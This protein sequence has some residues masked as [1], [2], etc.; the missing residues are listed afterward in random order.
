MTVNLFCVLL[1]HEQYTNNTE[2]INIIILHLIYEMIYN[3]FGRNLIWNALGIWSECSWFKT[4]I[5]TIAYNLN[6]LK[7]HFLWTYNDFGAREI[8]YTYFEFRFLF[9]R[10]IQSFCVK[11]F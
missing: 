10:C 2:M 9:C 4:R 1:V 5:F 6:M 11:Q 8:I 3:R 7:V